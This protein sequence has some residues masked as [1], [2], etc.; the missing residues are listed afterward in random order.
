MALGFASLLN[1]MLLSGFIAVRFVTGG[2]S[3]RDALVLLLRAAGV[4]EAVAIGRIG[5]ISG[6]LLAGKMLAMG[7]DTPGVMSALAQGILLAG[8]AVFYRR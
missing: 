8:I 1:A 7:T 3:V 6:P 2:Q 5:A 4:G